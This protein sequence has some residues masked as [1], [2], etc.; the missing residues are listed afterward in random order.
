ME[1]AYH[2]VASTNFAHR[3]QINNK[4]VEFATAIK[5]AHKDA[6]VTSNLALYTSPD[7][8]VRALT[9][10]RKIGTNIAYV[11]D[12]KPTIVVLDDPYED[13]GWTIEMCVA[14]ALGLEIVYEADLK[15]IAEG[16]EWDEKLQA[17]IFPGKLADAKQ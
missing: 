9:A 2:I 16:A 4:V 3:D 6:N 11:I 1:K 8:A 5:L 13:M 17:V 10:G 12:N 7:E 15:N 14:T